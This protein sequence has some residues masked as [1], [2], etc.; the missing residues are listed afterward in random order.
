MDLK[1]L[2]SAAR[3]NLEK[4]SNRVRSLAPGTIYNS[5]CASTLLP[6]ISAAGLGDWGPAGA[7]CGVLGSMGGGLVAGRIQEWQKRSE[8]ELVT[9]LGEKAERDPKWREALDKL[10]E[11]FDAPRIVQS[12]LSDTDKEWF[13]STLKDELSKLGN[14]ERYQAM[15]VGDGAIAQGE[16]AKGAGKRGVAAETI[17]DSIVIP[18]DQNLAAKGHIVR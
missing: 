14:L 12:A 4:L 17:Q 8:A 3:S 18:G 10:L 7:L 9:E 1:E 2:K 6:V 11:E 13:A 5:L 15:L 16:G